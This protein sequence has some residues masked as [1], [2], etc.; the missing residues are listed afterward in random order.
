MPRVKKKSVEYGNRKRRKLAA[1]K[2]STLYCSSPVDERQFVQMQSMENHF[3]LTVTP[4][5]SPPPP[6]P[7]PP[8]PPLQPSQ[9]QPPRPTPQPTPPPRPP[10]PTTTTTI[11]A[12]Y[13]PVL[14]PKSCPVEVQTEEKCLDPLKMEDSKTELK[15]S[16]FPEA[17]KDESLSDVQRSELRRKYFSDLLSRCVITADKA[18]A[19]VMAV[20]CDS[21]AKKPT[22]VRKPRVPRKPKVEKVNKQKVYAAVSKVPHSET[23]VSKAPPTP[24]QTATSK[25]TTANSKAI[26]STPPASNTQKAYALYVGGQLKYIL[27]YNGLLAATN[28]NQPEGEMKKLICRGVNGKTEIALAKPTIVC[29]NEK[30]KIVFVVQ[31]KSP[32]SPNQ[33]VTTKTTT[34][35][36]KAT[37][38]SS[39]LLT[40]NSFLNHGI[41]DNMLKLLLPSFVPSEVSTTATTTTTTTKSTTTPILPATTVGSNVTSAKSQSDMNSSQTGPASTDRP[42]DVPVTTCVNSTGNN[43]NVRT[44]GT[45]LTTTT[46]STKTLTTAVVTSTTTPAAAT[47]PTSTAATPPAP[48][49]VAITP[50]AAAT[51][52]ET[53]ADSGSVHPVKLF[54]RDSARKLCPPTS[55][56]LS[57]APVPTIL[58]A[59]EVQNSSGKSLLRFSS[60][61]NENKHKTQS[62]SKQTN[63]TA[64]AA[65][66][67]TNLAPTESH[68]DNIVHQD[69]TE[70]SGKAI[71]NSDTNFVKNLSQQSESVMEECHSDGK[72][73]SQENADDADD[74]GM[75]GLKISSVF[76]LAEEQLRSSE[77][78]V[79]ASQLGENSEFVKS[80]SDS[81]FFHVEQPQ[82][83]GFAE[84]DN[85]PNESK[86]QRVL[87]NSPQSTSSL[88]SP[89]TVVVSMNNEAFTS[90]VQLTNANEEVS[91]DISIDSASHTKH[92]ST[93]HEKTLTT[94]SPPNVEQDLDNNFNMTDSQLNNSQKENASP[95]NSSSS[96]KSEQDPKYISVDIRR[97]NGQTK[98]T[99]VTNPNLKKESA[100]SIAST[101]ESVSSVTSLGSVIPQGN[102][103]TRLADELQCAAHSLPMGKYVFIPLSDKT[104]AIPSQGGKASRSAYIFEKSFNQNSMQVK[105]PKSFI[106]NTKD[107]PPP[108][109]VSNTNNGSQIVFQTNNAS[110]S[111]NDVI[112]TPSADPLPSSTKETV[113][114]LEAPPIITGKRIR[115]PKKHTGFE[116]DI[117]FI[118][119]VRK[120][121]KKSKSV[122]KEKKSGMVASDN[123]KKMKSHVPTP[124]NN[125][126]LYYMKEGSNKIQLFDSK[127]EL[128][129][130]LRATGT[131]LEI[132]K[133]DPVNGHRLLPSCSTPV[134]PNVTMVTPKVA[135]SVGT[136]VDQSYQSCNSS[137]LRIDNVLSLQPNTV[138][139]KSEP[140]TSGYGDEPVKH[141]PPVSILPLNPLITLPPTSVPD[142]LNLVQNIKKEPVK[143]G[144]EGDINPDSSVSLLAPINQQTSLSSI[145]EE[146]FGL[147]PENVAFKNLAS[148]RKDVGHLSDSSKLYKFTLSGSGKK[149]NCKKK[150]V[151]K[152]AAVK[153][154]GF[155]LETQTSSSSSMT[156]DLSYSTPSPSN[157]SPLLPASPSTSSSSCYSSHVS[158]SK[159]NSLELPSASTSSVTLSGETPQEE[160]IRRLREILREKEHS[161]ELIRQNLAVS[162]SL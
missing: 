131:A 55:S 141:P 82:I 84:N 21:V 4:T 36:T 69:K 130:V 9:L 149:L 111:L 44:S 74:D 78:D 148:T 106:V 57:S 22:A 145:K 125:N 110:K 37:T 136:V 107:G 104:V 47:P 51:V 132:S 40:Y 151:G 77:D 79:T 30:K 35:E 154:T 162:S 54:S 89:R 50:A 160:R 38:K 23:A 68:P 49:A 103:S 159:H 87:I 134:V 3:Q 122:L 81:G 11:K 2:R 66:E 146:K 52:D 65:A 85:L 5:P 161:L 76:S 7:V 45:A 157:L 61:L 135:S 91:V 124:E 155:P 19:A 29:D 147:C 86:F 60:V 59:S 73:V 99:A 137:G 71:G 138:H 101:L 127:S 26:G 133:V 119:P 25:V 98:V 129:T 95:K 14:L 152:K 97:R 27:P 117:D 13:S 62:H 70:N 90:P 18:A 140:I 12:R 156:D 92:P 41:S 34:T 1:T 114:T 6:P 116:E 56:S 31:K 48:A 63:E 100:K 121:R 58:D 72:E 144:Y 43:Q 15:Y 88:L 16:T 158:S 20:R 64:A 113:P 96:D 150:T 94:K 143:Y 17:L 128:A 33:I 32:D 67:R 75:F 42:K 123:P 153:I 24:N 108:T 109:V 126:C 8:P 118:P 115:R 53:A 120:Y 112:T 142:S 139:I 28:P 102:S 93:D 39:N 80:S 10:P 83:D 105:M 46:T